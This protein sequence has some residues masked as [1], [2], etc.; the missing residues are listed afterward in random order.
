MIERA[1]SVAAL[2]TQS[3]AFMIP[4]FSAAT[5][6]TVSPSHSRWSR[7]TLVITQPPRSA[8]LVLSSRPPIPTSQTTQSARW[9]AAARKPIAVSI[10]NW[11]GCPPGGAPS[12]TASTSPARTAKRSSPSGSPSRTIRSPQRTR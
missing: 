3:F 11:V 2:T 8:T 7:A 12:A 1:G 9:R 6:S 10:S 5:A 4:A